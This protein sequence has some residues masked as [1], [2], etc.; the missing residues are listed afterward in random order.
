VSE[1]WISWSA[2]RTHEECKQKGFLQRTGKKATLNDTRVFFPGT[3]TDRV[4]RDWLAN[5]DIHPSDNLGA[6]PGMVSEIM[7][8]E[9]E[10]I[11]EGDSG[12]MVWK[13]KGDRAEVEKQCIEA[14]TKIEPALL[15]FV[16]PYEYM[17]DFRF[18]APL[19]L[20]H[21]AGGTELVV[22]NGYMDIIVKDDKGRFWVWDVKHTRDSSYWKKTAGQIGFYDLAVEIMFGQPTIRSGLLQ[23][24]ALPIVKPIPTDADARSV[25]M[26][27]I[28]SMAT[29]VWM[30]NKEPRRDN[31]EC[32]FCQVK[33]ACSKW[34]PTKSGDRRTLTF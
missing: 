20:P 18:K 14:V 17:A 10:L 33:H 32:G 13:N 22:L 34:Q 31:K 12:V 3:V 25:T 2:L 28:A 5:T 9:R 16:V 15:K 24:L 19:R 4:V 6:M 11:N 21:P 23:P 7:D 29:D 26:S 27:R 8:R 30:G 1:L